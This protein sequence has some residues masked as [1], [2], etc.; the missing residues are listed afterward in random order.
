MQAILIF[1]FLHFLGRNTRIAM[2]LSYLPLS[3]ND[4]D[5][6]SVGVTHIKRY[7]ESILS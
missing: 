6:F 4:S 5:K 1:F 3:T 7:Q 2:S